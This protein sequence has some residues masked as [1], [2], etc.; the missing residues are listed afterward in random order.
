MKTRKRTPRVTDMA[1]GYD[2]SRPV[3]GKYA[4]PEGGGTPWPDCVGASQGSPWPR[5]RPVPV[6]RIRSS[7]YRVL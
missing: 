4:R 7:D 2:F 6:W 5:S 3:R 1:K